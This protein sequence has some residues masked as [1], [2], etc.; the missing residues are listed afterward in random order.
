MADEK[1]ISEEAQK[2]IDSM[3]ANND[4]L[5]KQIQVLQDEKAELKDSIVNMNKR[6][7]NQELTF[8]DYA[9]KLM[10]DIRW[11]LMMATRKVQIRRL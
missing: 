4:E 9:K 5:K 7:D 2:I 10:E 1:N 3:Q 8:K 6:Q 11:L